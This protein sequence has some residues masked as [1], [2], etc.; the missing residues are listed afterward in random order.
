MLSPS[1]PLRLLISA[2]PA[3]ANNDAGT[4]YQVSARKG[5]TMAADSGT[6]KEARCTRV[7]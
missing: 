7:R 3:L 6:G 5:V 1:T 2:S 4:E